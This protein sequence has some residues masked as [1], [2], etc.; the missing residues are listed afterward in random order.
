MSKHSI[1]HRACVRSSS[2]SARDRLILGALLTGP[3]LG[4]LGWD[5]LNPSGPASANAAIP[6]EQTLDPSLLAGLKVRKPTESEAAARRYCAGLCP[7]TSAYTTPMLLPMVEGAVDALPGVP[8]QGTV[9]SA[10]DVRI[11]SFLRNSDGTVSIFAGGAL[12]SVGDELDESG[13]TI[14]AIDAN[15]RTVTV[16]HPDEAQPLVLEQGS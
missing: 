13:W 8:A 14:T 4:T 7:E 16:E 11:A 3:A 5:A 2:A 1:K 12:L 15:A 6:A 9:A 10:P